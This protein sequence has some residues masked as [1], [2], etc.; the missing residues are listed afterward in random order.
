M[1]ISGRPSPRRRL[2]SRGTTPR[3][4]RNKARAAGWLPPLAWLDID[5]PAETPD[6]S[7]IDDEVDEVVVDRLLGG[8]WSLRATRAERWEVIERWSGSD[9]ELERRTGWN[10]GPRSPGDACKYLRHDG[11]GMTVCAGERQ[12]FIRDTMVRWGAEVN[13]KNGPNR[14][15]NTCRA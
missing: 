1:R 6:L 10:C 8:D 3:A 15:A 2:E 7:A 9:N 5:N 12:G 11:G 4:Q 14:C 13:T